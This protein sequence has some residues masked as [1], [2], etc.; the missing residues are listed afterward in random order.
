MLPIQQAEPQDVV[1][2]AILRTLL[3]NVAEIW[4]ILLDFIRRANVS[5]MENLRLRD[6]ELQKTSC[7]LFVF[8]DLT[9]F[10]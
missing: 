6:Q 4:P 1:V 5:K 3:V 7:Y 8:L 10:V 9:S 2:R